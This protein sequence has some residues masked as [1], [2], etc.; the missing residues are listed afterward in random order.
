[1]FGFLVVLAV[2]G[3]AL[4]SHQRSIH[5]MLHQLK[6][7]RHAT[8]TRFQHVS[9]WFVIRVL[10]SVSVSIGFVPWHLP[11]LACSEQVELFFLVLICH[12]FSR[13]QEFRIENTK[14]QCCTM[15]HRNP[16]D[17]N[18][19]TCDREI[20]MQCIA[21][22]FGNVERLGRRKDG[23]N[24]G[25]KIIV[26]LGFLPT[27]V[28]LR[29]F[30][31][32]VRSRV[33]IALEKGLG[34]ASWSQSCLQKIA[35][36]LG[37]WSGPTVPKNHQ[38]SRSS[39]ISELIFGLSVPTW[40]GDALPV[41]HCCGVSIYVDTIGCHCWKTSRWKG[42]LG[43]LEHLF[44]PFPLTTLGLVNLSGSL[45]KLL[46]TKQCCWEWAWARTRTRTHRDTEGMWLQKPHST[47]ERTHFR[48][49]AL[50]APVLCEASSR[51]EVRGTFVL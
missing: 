51:T 20:L 49:R 41:G 34:N 5:Q 30:E 21:E 37:N 19:L 45:L 42:R 27:G 48:K 23:P 44:Y 43:I 18:P 24:S 2:F 40:G 25:L 14:S 28:A 29:K 33:R 32:E 36:T 15:G 12:E 46:L 13:S 50:L 10:Q 22:W 38:K 8:A 1:M 39:C 17:Q 31:E 47:Q 11:D 9:T 16:H 6:E 4:R 26:G 3:H 35:S 7:P